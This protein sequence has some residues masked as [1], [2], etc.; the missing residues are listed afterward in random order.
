MAISPSHT[1]DLLTIFVL[2]TQHTF[3]FTQTVTPTPLIVPNNG[4]RARNLVPSVWCRFAARRKGIPS[5]I[6]PKRH[7]FGTGKI[8]QHFIC[9]GAYRSRG[10]DSR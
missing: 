3:H 7:R 5:T 6:P 8:S 4:N 9:F 2:F 10:T 1:L